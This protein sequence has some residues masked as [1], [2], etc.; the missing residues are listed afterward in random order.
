MR[1]KGVFERCTS[2]GSGLFELFSRYFK[3]ILRQIVFLRVATLSST[4]LVAL[5]HI[6]AEKRS[7]PVAVRR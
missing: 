1:Y 7:F 2:A 4:N 3:K 6:K 5:G